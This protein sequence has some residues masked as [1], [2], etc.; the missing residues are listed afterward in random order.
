MATDGFGHPDSSPRRK[1]KD[2]GLAD[3]E[4]TLT[5]IAA[6]IENLERILGQID[7][8]LNN[9]YPV[10]R[11][12][13]AFEI[14]GRS[15]KNEFIQLRGRESKYNGMDEIAREMLVKLRPLYQ[16]RL[17]TLNNWMRMRFA[18]TGGK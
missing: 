14:P 5:G 4:I 11:L 16:S 1:V 18:K 7:E 2:D 9:K 13:V 6:E 12:A 3:G 15:D 17:D 10:Q 8:A